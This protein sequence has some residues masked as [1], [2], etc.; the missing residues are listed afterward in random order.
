MKLYADDPA[1]RA[2]QIV[3]DL[4][5]LLAIAL[6]IAI[7]VAVRGMIAALGEVGIRLEEAGS[8]FGGTMSEIGESLGQ[9]PLIGPG[10][11]APFQGASDAGQSLAEAGRSVHD[12]VALIATV[13]GL[14][15]AVAPIA[16][17]LLLWL[18]PRLRF[19]ARAGELAALVRS[20]APLDLLALRALA[21]RKPAQLAAIH[22]DPAGAWR[23]GDPAVVR[24]LA[25][26]ELRRA[27]VALP[28]G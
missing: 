4:A 10:I 16:A 7:G 27:G 28:R 22:P 5:A 8:G 12:T 17:I 3:F 18:V 14:L 23:R 2:W 26:L 25:A 24:E 20:G 1:R 13:V 19:A 21:R 15:V 11:A 9:V 6:C